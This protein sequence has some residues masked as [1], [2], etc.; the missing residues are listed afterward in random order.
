MKSLLLSIVLVL[1]L[2][3]VAGQDGAPDAA[4][5]LETRNRYETVLLKNPF[6]ERAFNSV[7]EGYGRVEGVDAWVAKLLPSSKE[8][9]GRAAALLLLGQIYDRQFKTADALT[10]LEQ[11]GQLGE[12]RPQFQVLLGTL[13]YKAGKDEAAA[14]LLGQALD[15][16]TDLDQRAAVSRLL[17]NLYLRQGKRDEAVAVWKRIT[18]QN[19]GE[20]FA[21]LELAEIYED[22]RMWDQA[23]EVYRSVATEAKD[24]P[25]R[26]CRALRSIGQCQVQAEKFKEAI[27]TYEQALGLVAPGNWLFEDLKLRLVGVYEDIGDLE[28][29]KKYVEARLQQNA[30]DGEFRDLL[31]ETLIRLGQFDAA[32]QQYREML[33]RSPRSGHVHE[34]LI[35]LYQ[36]TSKREAVVASYEKLIELFP[37]DPDY[38]RR[39]GEFY[40]RENQPDKAKETWRR[41]AKGTPSAEALG[42]LAGWFESFEFPDEAIQTYQQALAL[43]PNGDWTD[44]QAALRFQKGEEAEAVRLWLSLATPDSS[45]EDLANVAAILESNGRLDESLSLRQQA[46]TKEPGN[47]EQQLALGKSLL[48]KQK[49]TEAAATFELLAS[50]NTNEFLTLQGEQGRLDAWRELGVLEEKQKALEDDLNAHPTDAAK[51]GQL[52]RFYERSGQREKAVELYEVRRAKEPDNLDYLR[53]LAP[54]YEST[55]Q[56]ESALTAYQTLLEKDKSRARVYQQNLLDLYLAADQKDES[57]RAAEALVSL[58]PGD[59]EIRLTLAQVY[60]TYRLPEKAL[61]EFR[62]ALRLEPNEPEYYRRYGEV[63]ESEKRY[64]EAQEAYRKMLDTAK[65]DS[66]RIAAVGALTRIHTL[67]DRLNDLVAEFQRRI[68]NTPKKLA[69]YEELAVIYRE[70]GQVSR[71]VEVLESGLNS[72]DDKNAALR[73]LIRASF[74]AQDFPKV[75]SYFEQLVAA[76]GKPTANEFERLGQIYAQLGEIEKARQTWMRIVSE[77]PKDAKAH[78]RLAQILRD[79]GLTDEAIAMKGRAVELDPTDLKRR[80]DFSQLLAQSEQPVEAI[81]Q[82]N[83]ILELGAAEP[84]PEESTSE[85][86]V[87]SVNRGQ[88][89]PVSSAQFMY[90][91]SAYRGGYYGGG[92]QGTFRQFRPQL[93]TFMAN[94]AQQ[95][96]GEDALVE[97]FTERARK[98]GAGSEAQ[99]DL[100]QILQLYNRIPEALKVSQE[101]LARY[102]KDPDLLQQVALF[103]QSQQQLDQAIPLMERLAEAQPKQRTQALQGLVP[104]YFQNKQEEKALALVDQL[105][106]DNPKDISTVFAMGNFLQQQGKRDRARA[107]YTN[108]LE[109]DPNLRPNLLSALAQM[110]LQ[111]NQP[112]AARALYLEMLKSPNPSASRV[113]LVS[114]QRQVPLY[115]PQIAR[116]GQ[117]PMM[118][119]GGIGMRRAPQNVFGYMDYMR[120]NALGQLKALEKRPDAD[121]NA[122]G[123]VQV[124]E[125]VARGYTNAV[126]ATARAQAWDTAKFL[127]AYQLSEKQEDQA[128]SLLQ[129]FRQAGYQGV[130]WFNIALYLAEQKEDLAGMVQLYDQVLQLYPAKSR[131]VAQAKAITLV[132][133]K[134]YDGAAKVIRDMNQQ[135]VPPAQILTMISAVRRAGEKKLARELLEEHLA[136]ASRNPAALQELAQL[137]GEEN[138]FAK[139]IALG[140]EAWDRKAHGRSSQNYFYGPGTYFGGIGGISGADTLLSDLFRYYVAEGRSDE[141]IGQFKQRLEK[142]PS[143]IAAHE[144]LAQLYRLADNR[145]A[146]LELYQELATKR[147]HLVQVRQNIANLYVEMGDTKRATEYFEDL[148]KANPLS[149][150]QFQWELRYLY[151]RMGK[152]KELAQMEERLVDKARDPN[153]IREVADRLK[154]EGEYEK[155]AE[156][157]RKAIKMSPGDPWVRNQ[158][159]DVFVNLGKYDEAVTLYKEWL[160][161]PQMRSQPWVDHQAMMRLA[162]LFR[163]TGRIEELKERAATA[164]KN[165][166]SDLTGL[167]LQIHLALLDKRIADAIAG[168]K[169]LQEAGRDP[170]GMWQLMD[171][172]AITGDYGPIL[173]TLEKADP[174]SL[175]Q[176]Q[177]A[178]F[179]ASQGDLKKAE[180]LVFENVERQ[181][182]NGN[183]GWVV[184]Q[185]IELLAALDNWEAAERLV[186]KFREQ[187]VQEWERREIDNEIAENY[188]QRNQ[189]GSVVEDILKKDS[190]KGRDLDLLKS[191]LER[192]Q[193]QSQPER[194]LEFLERICRADP[195]N[196]ELQYA[197]ATAYDDALQGDRKLAILER[198]VAEE[199]ANLNYR[200]QL[201]N[202]LIRVGRPSDGVNG[203]RQWVDEKP[204]EQRWVTYSR[205]L[206]QAGRLAESRAALVKAE[207]LADPSRKDDLHL[208]LTAFDSAW[209]RAAERKAALRATFE[210]KKDQ[211]SFQEYLSFLDEQGYPGEAHAFF[212]ANKEGGY[213]EQYQGNAPFNLCFNASDYQTP[214]DVSWRFTRY[215]ERWNRNN[216]FE[217]TSRLFSDRGKSPLLAADLDVRLNAET[218]SNSL[219]QQKRAEAW[220]TAGESAKALAIYEELAKAQPFDRSLRSARSRLLVRLGREAEA[221]ELLRD[222]RGALSLR[223]EVAAR[224]ELMEMLVQLNR[225][226]EAQKELDSLL[227]WSKGG[228]TLERAG[229]LQRMMKNWGRAAEFYEASRKAV[230]GYNDAS[231]RVRLGQCYAKTDRPKE[232]LKTWAELEVGV[233]SDRAYLTSPLVNWLLSEGMAPLAI[234]FGELRAAQNSNA[235]NAYLLQ[236]RGHLALGQTNEAFAALGR[237]TAALPESQQ[238]SWSQQMGR[239]L[240]DHQLAEAAWGQYLAQPNP[241][242]AGALIYSTPRLR[243]D[244]R[245]AEHSKNLAQLAPEKP[246]DQLSLGRALLE[247]KDPEA[248]ATQFRRALKSPQPADQREAIKGLAEAGQASAATAEV[249]TLLQRQPQW[250]VEDPSLM[251]AAAKTRDTAVVEALKPILTAAQISESQGQAWE[252]L[253]EFHRGQTNGAAAKLAALAAAP[254]LTAAQLDALAKLSLEAGFTG[255]RILMLQRMAEPGRSSSRRQPALAE[256]V[257]AQAAQRDYQAALTALAQL[258]NVWGQEYCV[259]ARETLAQSVTAET[260]PKFQEAVIAVGRVHATNDVVS[261]L[262]GFGAQVGARV[263]QE[264]SAGALAEKAGLQGL[265]LEEAQAWDQL[266]E[267]WEVTGP[268]ATGPAR[269][270]TQYDYTNDGQSIARNAPRPLAPEFGPQTVWRPTDP[271]RELGAIQLAQLLGLQVADTAGQFAFA[272]TTLI[273]PDDRVVNLALGSDDTVEVWVNGQQVHASAVPRS[274]R[275]DQDRFDVRLRKGD[276]EVLLRIG[277]NTDSWA[278]CLRVLSGR[279]GLTLAQAPK[280]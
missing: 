136:G 54:L 122:M 175:D 47:L 131:E 96:I 170:N 269:N 212:V 178:R 88:T 232:A 164:L 205:V 10:A 17:G 119:I 172:A 214:L 153:Q 187:G 270:E 234:Q 110:E 74:E 244:R 190:F 2:G 124:L 143:S 235:P 183:G 61:T 140:N 181:M 263:G 92:W 218:N 127:I 139:A 89:S 65:E 81:K 146:A 213:L 228:E 273:S 116:A 135:R 255:E 166:P 151:Q 233:S 77:S 223:E 253:V 176:S 32:E 150:Q 191:I 41:L 64:G 6:Q 4:R 58:A 144:N 50:Q 259:E 33:E 163:A 224:F 18:E 199:P 25:Y 160:D 34:K 97:Q 174:G 94:V 167:G 145:K 102:P 46:V 69:A 84:P 107:V 202:C 236:A 229:D 195:K 68:R 226:D 66:T 180:T 133:A 49:F 249:L 230:R 279:D 125:T 11:A 188:V 277:N 98:A 276:N 161:S 266:I 108:A 27:A 245:F 104:L 184:R 149:Y 196:R 30:G 203:F 208:Q 76:S 29:L 95:S 62:T 197:L 80:F 73:A 19:P 72:V 8:G 43:K 256:L 251:V 16:L 192:Y 109:L 99:R 225:A 220:L 121:T 156:M 185:S 130:D 159:A 35:A 1:L 207:E 147:P 44:R 152:G 271:R 265:E 42:T 142:Q 198:L 57:I 75:K 87:K 60:L 23:I 242:L 257:K 217:T 171:L 267:Q 216:Y 3:R 260:W 221:L 26:Q 168:Y 101:L 86:K 134:D 200:E 71:G 53:A 194:R 169:A 250:F 15:S 268:F 138:E 215:G 78:D 272:R 128:A 22:N 115:V 182:G 111:D 157:Y 82:L 7:Y 222:F 90:G 243:N 106:K 211:G 13:Y 113:S 28:G 141:I 227:A 83:L 280:K 177:L 261:G 39:L 91:L 155:A 219:M 118:M 201:A 209:G 48:R 56:V 137:Y 132:K 238:D 258:I 20:A 117:Q 38:L 262:I 85:K 126:S 173:A 12:S 9:E 63:L 186:R 148:I 210:T 254:D 52:A 204:L 112:A 93:I 120:Q 40:L 5:E 179:Y 123:F 240:V 248:A 247:L 264:V 275:P 70:S 14:K 274:L 206:Q 193:W 31:A 162:A 59:P 79:A 45:V 114:G 158:L 24:D 100:V 165:N 21:Q 55:K 237:G 67:Q 231:I 246:K 37:T 103:Y 105:L 36:R 154:E 252:F 239:L 189:F 278:Y 51:L 129:S 241:V